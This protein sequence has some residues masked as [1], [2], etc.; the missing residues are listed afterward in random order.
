MELWVLVNET[1]GTVGAFGNSRVDVEDTDG[2]EEPS[3]FT[4]CIEKVYVVSGV[5][6]A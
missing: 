3:E 2:T 6:L 4:A 5:R 1:N